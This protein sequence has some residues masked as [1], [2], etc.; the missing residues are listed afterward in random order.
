MNDPLE[1][2]RERREVL[3]TKAVAEALGYTEST[4]RVVCTGRYPGDPRHILAKVLEVYVNVVHC[5]HIG[6]PVSLAS[7][8]LRATGP[9]PRGGQA[10]ALWWQ[11]CQQCPRRP[12][13]GG[14]P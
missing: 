14:P 11:A 13:P 3:G 2:L 10:R 5:P 7:C 9:R 12:A 1:V 6:E 8:R 4:I